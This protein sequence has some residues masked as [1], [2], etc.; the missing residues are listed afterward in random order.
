VDGPVTNRIVNPED[1]PEPKGYA[2]AVVS[3]PGTLVHLGG[4][5]GHQADGS[6]S[7]DDLVAQ[8]DQACANVI[9]ALRAAG[10]GPED[11]VQ[12][13]IFA[14]DLEDYRAR[15][16]EL[17]EAYR[18]HFGTHYPAMALLGTTALVD[19]RALVEL[20]GTAVIPG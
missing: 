5:T 12:L 15:R 4:Q 6:L 17:G 9:I 11:L 10:G 16:K 20:V 19:P 13:V 7:E 14:T 8:F 1:L 18:R 2:H 3:G